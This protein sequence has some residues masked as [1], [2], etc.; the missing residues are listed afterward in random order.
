MQVAF[1]SLA[2]FRS[3]TLLFTI[4]FSNLFGWRQRKVTDNARVPAN[5]LQ[6][7]ISVVRCKSTPV[8]QPSQIATVLKTINFFFDAQ[9][10]G[11]Q[12]EPVENK[13]GPKTIAKLLLRLKKNCNSILHQQHPILRC[14]FVLCCIACYRMQKLKQMTGQTDHPNLNKKKIWKKR[15]SP[16]ISQRQ[17]VCNGLQCSQLLFG[18]FFG[19]RPAGGAGEQ[20]DR[21]TAHRTNGRQPATGQITDEQRIFQITNELARPTMKGVKKS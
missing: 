11:L 20:T 9:N 1:L 19:C 17:Q 15:L 10:N 13:L 8:A 12:K 16:S 6:I 18:H 2:R 3:L 7:L 21:A 5:K 14:H 4:R